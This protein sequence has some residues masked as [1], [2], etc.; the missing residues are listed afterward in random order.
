[1][2]GTGLPRVAVIGGGRMGLARWEQVKAIGVVVPVCIVEMWEE[3]RND[4][5]S[6]G[7]PVVGSLDDL[8]P[9]DGAVVST[10]TASHKALIQQLAKRNIH[11]Y[12]EKPISFTVSEIRECYEIARQHGVQL[13]AGW[14]KRFDP[15]FLKVKRRLVS[16]GG[17]FLHVHMVNRDFPVPPKSILSQLGDIWSDCTV[18]EFNLALW[19]SNGEMPVEVFARGVCA[20]GEESGVM[21]RSVTHLTFKGGRTMTIENSRHSPPK[22]KY[23]Q[24]LEVVTASELL[25]TGFPQRDLH[26]LPDG[27]FSFPQRYK[28]AFE[29]EM[30]FFAQCIQAA[31]KGETPPLPVNREEDDV[32]TALLA[33]AC[34]RSN[35]TRRVVKITTAEVGRP[36][37]AVLSFDGAP[38]GLRFVGLGVFGQNMFGFVQSL[39]DAGEMGGVSLLPPFTRK[40]GLDWEKDVLRDGET[41]GV[42]ICTP[43]DQH[44]WQALEC[45]QHGKAVLVEKPLTKFE[46]LRRQAV[47][48]GVV[49]MVGFQRRFDSRVR[50]AKKFIE[51]NRQRVK[52]VVFLSDEPVPG[53]LPDDLE[54]TLRNSCCHECDLVSFLFPS[55][56]LKVVE[57][58]RTGVNSLRVCLDAG[59][60]PVEIRFAK[61]HK[62]FANEIVVEAN[63]E[64]EGGENRKMMF[65]FR[66]V[67]REARTVG[68]GGDGQFWC[69]EYASA[70]KQMFRTF[71]DLSKGSEEVVQMTGA[72]R[73]HGRGF[74]LLE[75]VCGRWRERGGGRDTGTAAV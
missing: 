6:Q 33:E 26:P 69:D 1:M 38:F 75:E 43:D 13:H 24:R 42:Y 71:C 8:P 10:P 28:E 70:Y 60:V 37:G 32:N 45:L 7:Y 53:P 23:D 57:V 47:G 54:Q 9:V 18:H 29:A 36:G 61:G 55:G 4:L 3:K 19:L 15:D 20:L 16:L 41:A 22:E 68:G 39:V 25:E 12:C 49:M 66:G 63:E 50:E 62:E 2:S 34:N 65:G 27:D 56:D 5:L 52:R 58:V 14:M 48:S 46:Q 30:A 64:K 17:D 72:L 73:S 31:A 59:G 40:S 35:L 74:S 51:A 67:P 21:D 44:D 11:I